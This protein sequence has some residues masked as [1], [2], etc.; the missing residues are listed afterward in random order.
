MFL[1]CCVIGFLVILFIMNMC[2]TQNIEDRVN[3]LQEEVYSIT[4]ENEELREYVR[5][6]IKAGELGEDF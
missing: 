3:Y 2:V 5:N 1:L 6:L 4:K